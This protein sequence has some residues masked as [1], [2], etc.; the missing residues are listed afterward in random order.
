[1]KNIHW[2]IAATA[3]LALSFLVKSPYVAF[4]LYAFLLLAIIANLSS[5]AWLSGLEC[6]RKIGATILQQGDEVC[7]GDVLCILEV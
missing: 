4:S 7:V 3:I 6:E 2:F 5:R 1:M